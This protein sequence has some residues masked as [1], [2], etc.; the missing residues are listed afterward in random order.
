MRKFTFMLI[1]ILFA[2][3]VSAQQ[4]YL[5]SK[6][7]D[8]TS[9]TKYIGGQFI[10]KTSVLTDVINTK[11]DLF[12]ESFE[13]TI[14][15]P[16]G[17]TKIDGTT[18]ALNQWKRDGLS[19]NT[20]SWGARVEYS[21]NTQNEWLI[22]PTVDLTTLNVP[23][24]EFWW[25]MSYYWGVDPNDNYDF[26]IKVSTNGGTTWTTIWTE[27]SAGSFESFKYLKKEISLVPYQTS[28]TFK[29]AFQYQGADGADLYIDDIRIGELP[30]NRMEFASI[31]AGYSNYNNYFN[32]MPIRDW[33]GYS[34][35]PF[36]QKLV[37]GMAADIKNTG[38]ATQNNVTFRAKELTTNSESASPN[39]NLLMFTNDTLQIDS[40]IT[41]ENTGNYKLALY[42]TSDSINTLAYIDT[43]D[44]DVNKTPI[45]VGANTVNMGVYSRD[46]NFYDGWGS[47]G[48]VEAGSTKPFQFANL[49]EITEPTYASSIEVVLSG[50]TKPGPNTMIKTILY[51]GWNWD[52]KY[53]VAESD[54]HVILASEI[55]STLDVLNPVSINLF[56]ANN[57]T[58]LLQK[59]SVYFA[60]VQGFGGTDTVYIAIGG[61]IPQPSVT[62]FVYDY[63]TNS[64]KWS[65]V[66]KDPKMIRLKVVDQ[67]IF[68]GI[69]EVSLNQPKLYQNSPNPANSYTKIAYDLKKQENV[70][71]DI[72]DLMGKK[73]LSYKMGSQS[74]GF[75]SIDVDLSKLTPGTYFYS[76]KTNDYQKTLKMI[77]W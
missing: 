31:W 13:G 6:R 63:S 32:D 5:E 23:V 36:G 39:T 15:P 11:A 49:Y 8:Q 26:R 66:E 50:M 20:G 60:T 40:L 47:W 4:N 9:K 55:P 56:F 30:E 17:W 70:A 74:A 73:I 14:F 68:I 3:T 41:F 77:I 2:V 61:Q 45:T 44:V 35:I 27:D 16:T 7:I 57:E 12:Y 65:D 76:L 37:V 42:A 72:F 64:W 34:R 75:H 51:R 69:N 48:G 19:P 58:P 54:Y 22:T 67:P 10:G 25:N 24:L 52:S 43:F 29:V 38:S 46:N 71:I 28:T 59:D 21:V 18:V 62:S 53:I 1:T 33:S